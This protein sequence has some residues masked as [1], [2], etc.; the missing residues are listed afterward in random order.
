MSS[1]AHHAHDDAARD[2]PVVLI[3]IFK[4]DA[5]HQDALMEGLEDLVRTQTAL[6]GFVSATLHRGLNGRVAANHAVWASADHWKAMTRHPKVVAAM[7][8]I[9][10]I[11]TF[12]P[13]L[14]EPGE[15]IKA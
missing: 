11:A 15:V 10:A 8:P 13:H 14:Y 7:G 4:C 6:P 2:E 9:L 3:N 5:R 1:D 12:E